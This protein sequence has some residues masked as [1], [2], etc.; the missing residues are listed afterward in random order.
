MGT[1]GIGIMNSMAFSHPANINSKV[2][3]NQISIGAIDFQ[4]HPP[5]LNPVFARLD[6]G[7]DQTIG[8]LSFHVGS[9]GSIRFL[10]STKSDPSARKTMTMAI[11]ESSVGS[12]YEVNSPVSFMTIENIEDKIEELDETMENL[13]LGEQLKDFMICCSSI[14][15][16]STDTW[17]TGL[18]LHDDNQTTLSS[19]SSKFENQYQ[20]L[21]IIGNNSEEFD[22]NNN[23]V[24]NP[25]NV[26]RGANHLAEGDT[27]D[28]LTNR[29]KIQLSADEWN[30]IKAAIEHGVAIPVDESKEVLLGYHYA[31]Q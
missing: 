7:M 4:P 19:C 27:A 13:E 12:S 3:R 30:T 17:K 25:T 26:T 16:K 15:D 10:D 1:L 23:Q 20:I 8:I 9:L 24:L 29:A 2:D 6:Q 11:S 5:T 31:L 22:D 18:E 28:S 14:S 21:A